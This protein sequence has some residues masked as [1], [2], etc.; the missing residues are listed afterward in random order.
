MCQDETSLLLE[1]DLTPSF[2]HYGIHTASS[3]EHVLEGSKSQKLTESH[4]PW[5]LVD[6][7]D[8]G[9]KF[10]GTGLD[11]NINNCVKNVFALS[12]IKAHLLNMYNICIF[13]ELNPYI[14]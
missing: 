9:P 5:A 13:W 3:H 11:N 14:Y 4:D 10:S 12:K 8:D 1:Q 6:W 7:K 2:P